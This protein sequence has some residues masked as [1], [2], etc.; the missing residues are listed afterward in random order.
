MAEALKEKTVN[1]NERVFDESEKLSVRRLV[2]K[3]NRSER[4]IRDIIRH[5]NK[6]GMF[7]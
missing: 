3:Y 5:H 7:A 4:T 2:R 6:W 1:R